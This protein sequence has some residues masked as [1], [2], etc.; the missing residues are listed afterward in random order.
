MLAAVGTMMFASAALAAGA[1]GHA[2]IHWGKHGI[3][4]GG[5]VHITMDAVHHHAEQIVA[6]CKEAGET[7]SAC[8]DAKAIMGL[9]EKHIH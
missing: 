2:G 1:G 6:N 3:S 5:G 8:T 9:A 7:H 4:F